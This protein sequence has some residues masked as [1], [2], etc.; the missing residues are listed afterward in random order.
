MSK[1]HTIA[2][3][4]K[5]HI[6]GA[7]V[8]NS[9]W[10]VAEKIYQMALSLV[11]SILTARYLGPSNMGIIT[12]AATFVAAF[13]PVALLSLEYVA[14]KE[15]V[16]MPEKAGEVLGSGIVM[17][18]V[19]GLLCFLLIVSIVSILKPNNKEYVIVAALNAISLLFYSFTLVESWLQSHLQSKYATIIKSIAYTI[20]SLYK[21]FL[22][23]TNKSVIWFAFA[24]SLDIIIIAMLY[25][26]LYIFKQRLRMTITR[27]M[28]KGLLVQSYPFI[29]SGLMVVAYGQLDR[30]IL[31]QYH[32]ANALGQYGIG[33]SLCYMWQFI[34]AAIITSA[35]PLILKA[36]ENDSVNYIRRLK[37]LYSF[38][39]WLSI[40]VAILFTLF[41][42]VIVNIMYGSEFAES[43]T[44]LKI[45]TWS[46]GFSLMA[47]VRTIWL[48]AEDKNK[49]LIPCQGLSAVFSIIL[50]LVL[51]PPYG[52]IGASISILVSQFFVAFI[53]TAFFRKTR[54][55]GKYMLD[56]IMMRFS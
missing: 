28:M 29:L 40:L 47:G 1:I 55:S 51:I 13:M 17:R 25:I 24:T 36:K 42:D 4:V 10:I 19:S 16:K 11:I 34:P 41:G 45:I 12:Y 32:G 33:A 26:Y 39:W 21:V 27:T 9:S 2:Q 50:Y 31:E 49:Y 52:I 15:I 44:A 14:V 5:K 22:L 48:I 54:V 46:Q 30:V 37:Q 43:A 56:A 8:T 3:F 38:L 7:F 18:F 23:V 6:G 53:S 35:R 20:M